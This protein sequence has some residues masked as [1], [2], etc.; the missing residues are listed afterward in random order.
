[1]NGKKT[2]TVKY[3]RVMDFFSS[4]PTSHS[5]CRSWFLDHQQKLRESLAGTVPTYP[6]MQRFNRKSTAGVRSVKILNI[7]HPPYLMLSF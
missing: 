5:L 1:M 3:I 4:G 7:G 2:F 6:K